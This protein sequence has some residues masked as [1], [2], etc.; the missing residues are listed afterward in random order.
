MLNDGVSKKAGGADVSYYHLLPKS[1][2]EDLIDGIY[3]I[4]TE[5]HISELSNQFCR[6]YFATHLKNGKEYFAIV[7]ERG[8]LPPIKELS[9]LKTSHSPFINNLL[10]YSLVRLSISKK[11]FICAIV[12]AYDPSETLQN[13]LDK[14][15]AMSSENVSTK[16]MPAMVSLLTFCEAHKINCNNI[17][18]S[19]IIFT[20][21]GTIKLREF[22]V[23]LPNFGQ[24]KLFL[25]PEIA[26]AM[27][28][29]RKVFGLHAD[30]YALGMTVYYSLTRSLPDF[31]KHNAALYNAIRIESRT[32]DY[33]VGRKRIA[34]E[35]AVI[36]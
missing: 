20:N 13:Y 30:I 35:Y 12:E 16:L 1:Y 5:R 8:F 11:H 36:S 28:I 34:S 4:H 17:C 2:K 24:D 27:P 32:Y 29:G 3:Q 14:N 10:A 31:G 7:F 21:D 26:D 22:F 9:L 6:Y 25:A 23:S 33:I 15:G 18:P 19:N